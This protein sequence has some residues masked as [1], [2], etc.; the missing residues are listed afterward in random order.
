MLPMNSQYY[1]EPIKYIDS[2]CFIYYRGNINPGIGNQ[3]AMCYNIAKKETWC[4]IFNINDINNHL[5][6]VYQK[7]T[8]GGWDTSKR[9]K[10]GSKQGWEQDQID[11]YEYVNKWNHKLIN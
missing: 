10:A 8:Y 3:Y 4:N 1:T 9:N 11:L 7:C 6:N 5:I 2:S